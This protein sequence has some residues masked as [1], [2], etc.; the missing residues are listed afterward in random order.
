MT[1]YIADCTCIMWSVFNDV[2]FNTAICLLWNNSVYPSIKISET[3]HFAS[4]KDK[5]YNH[6][7]HKQM[8]PDM[9]GYF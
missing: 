3:H 7:T 2:I 5:K 8:N 4:V 1:M 9:I 6:E